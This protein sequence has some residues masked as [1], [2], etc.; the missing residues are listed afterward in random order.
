MTNSNIGD[1]WNIYANGSNCN[2]SK[3]YLLFFFYSFKSF[4]Y[5]IRLNKKAIT[6][7]PPVFTTWLYSCYSAS[8][9]IRTW[10]SVISSWHMKMLWF[11]S[12]TEALL[13]H[14]GH[15]QS[16]LAVVVCLALFLSFHLFHVLITPLLWLFDDPPPPPPVALP[17]KKIHLS[18]L[19]SSFATELSPSRVLHN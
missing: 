16:I 1:L 4:N 14:I 18:K 10:G 17:E 11:I 15:F 12:R 7:P 2:S 8:R 13:L 3:C 6:S 5:L 19:C 9:K